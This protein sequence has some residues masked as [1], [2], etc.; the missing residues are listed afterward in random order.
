MAPQIAVKEKYA[1]SV[2]AAEKSAMSPVLAGCPDQR[3]AGVRGN[4]GRRRGPHRHDGG[5]FASAVSPG[6]YCSPSG[7]TGVGEANGERYTCTTSATDDRNR[8]RQ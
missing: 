8:W 1:L 7:A 4:R 3:T 5:W 6:A 2:T